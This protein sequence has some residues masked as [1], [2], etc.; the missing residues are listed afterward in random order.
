VFKPIVL[1]RRLELSHNAL[2]GYFLLPY[3]EDLFIQVP[4]QTAYSEMTCRNLIF[5]SQTMTYGTSG[6]Q[7]LQGQYKCR[8][9]N[10]MSK[11]IFLFY[12]IWQLTKLT[13]N[14]TLEVVTSLSNCILIY[15]IF[16]RHR[17]V[18]NTNPPVF[19]RLIFLVQANMMNKV[20]KFRR[21]S[22]IWPSLC[23]S[24]LRKTKKWAI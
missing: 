10:L 7:T 19:T 8:Y 11:T 16:N 23:H 2:S 17:N 20:A 21:T 4:Q 22:I 24:I 9:V 14:Q 1:K 12:F 15:R 13:P 5:L 3:P 18:Y 6:Q